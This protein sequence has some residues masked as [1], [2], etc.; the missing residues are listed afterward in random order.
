MQK[1]RY[2]STTL[3]TV[4]KILHRLIMSVESSKNKKNVIVTLNCF[5]KFIFIIILTATLKFFVIA[6]II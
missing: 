4:Y 6:M 3:A 1:E 2:A 5:R